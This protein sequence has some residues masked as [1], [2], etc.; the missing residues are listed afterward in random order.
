MQFDW[1]F[2]L[3]A[4]PLVGAGVLVNIRLALVIFAFALLGGTLL[5]LVRSLKNPV[6]NALIGVL[7]SFIRGTPLVIQIF[8]CFYAL[9]ALGIR[10]SPVTAGILRRGSSATSARLRG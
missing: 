10:L 8:L 4:L 2:F 9:P 5:T 3:D 6:V 7:I 1:A